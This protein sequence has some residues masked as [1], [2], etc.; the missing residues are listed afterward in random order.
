[1][2]MSIVRP[3]NFYGP[4]AGYEHV[5]PEIITRIRDRVD[6]FPLS[7]AGDTR[8]FC[9]IEDAVEA[10]L[11][12]LLSQSGHEIFAGNEGMAKND[13][14]RSFRPQSPHMPKMWYS[15]RQCHCA[16]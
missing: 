13:P 10:I 14:K 5:I 9:Y 1:M 4:R 15:L 12:P 7:G 16:G 8:S 2:R 6:P 3:H 11:R